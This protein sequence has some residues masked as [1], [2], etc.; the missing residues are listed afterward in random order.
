MVEATRRLSHRIADL[1]QAVAIV[2]TSATSRR[3]LD[4][5]RGFVVEPTSESDGGAIGIGR[6]H[7]LRLGLGTGATHLHYCDFDR[8]LH[9]IGHHP[10]ELASVLDGVTHHDYLMLGRTARAFATHPRVQRDTEAITNHAFSLW[11]GEAVDVA[12]GSCGVSREAAELLL[13]RSTARTNA[14]DA[15]WPALIRLSP[16]MAIGHVKTEGLEFETPDYFPDEIAAAG[17]LEAWLE[18]RSESLGSWIGRTRLTL[19]SLQ[20]L[21]GAIR[22]EGEKP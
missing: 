18:E 21:A 22:S 10:E 1:Y 16:G 3:L 8:V 12:A 9:W 5:L 17:S 14:T 15:E 11:F 6:R 19:E 4:A 7:A 13:R 2:P 20:A